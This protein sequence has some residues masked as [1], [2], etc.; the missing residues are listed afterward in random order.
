MF[1]LILAVI[2][3]LVLAA[4]CCWAFCYTFVRRRNTVDLGYNMGDDFLGPY[5]EEIRAGMQFLDT[6]EY[7]KVE[8]V[9]Y[10]GL[11]LKGRYYSCG[12]ENTVIVFH[13]YRSIGKRDYSCAVGMYMEMGLNVLMVDQRSHGES[14]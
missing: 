13:G 6:A 7:T 1:W 11:K 10:D 12:S 8:T 14:E 3:M 5:T 2:V 9:S 4:A